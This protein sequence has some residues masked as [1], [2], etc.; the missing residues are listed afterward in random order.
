M[1]RKEE[2]RQASSKYVAEIK[3]PNDAMAMR[4]D[5]EN[6]A[7]WADNNPRYSKGQTDKMQEREI[8]FMDDWLKEHHGEMPTFADAIAWAEKK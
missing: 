6:G 2:I 3:D 5:F 7:E 4:M 8:A 1:D